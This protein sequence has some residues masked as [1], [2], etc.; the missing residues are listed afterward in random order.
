MKRILK[1]NYLF[2]FCLLV[3]VSSSQAVFTNDENNLSDKKSFVLRKLP[4]N[5]NDS[6][7]VYSNEIIYANE[8]AV[9]YF[10]NTIDSLKNEILFLKNKIDSLHKINFNLSYSLY[11]ITKYKTEK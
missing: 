2:L 8:Q 10:F 6:V 4:E 1:N 3:V 5:Y 9:N 7:L 11:R